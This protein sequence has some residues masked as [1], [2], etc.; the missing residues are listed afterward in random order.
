VALPVE[1]RG[2]GRSL[3]AALVLSMVWMVILTL[4]QTIGMAPWIVV[5]LLLFTL[6]A[7][8]DF[9]TGRPAWLRLDTDGI[10]WRSGRQ[11]GEIVR[12]RIARVRFETRLDLSV[13]VRLVLDTG[14]RIT[15]PQ[16]SLPPWQT[17][18]DA[19]EAIGIPTE[20]HHFA[21]L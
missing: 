1:H 9:A 5:F 18:Q 2:S 4:W 14:K 10:A 12:N 20:R 19:F 3:R 13:R 8:W 16:D 21:L 7:A 15:L 11:S 17:L 6:P